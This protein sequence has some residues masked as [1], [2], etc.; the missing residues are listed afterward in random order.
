[1][2]RAVAEKLQAVADNLVVESEEVSL[3]SNLLQQLKTALDGKATCGGGSDDGSYDEGYAAGQQA[4][5]DRFWDA[6]QQ[7]GNRTDYRSAFFG[8]GWDG[9]SFRPK[10][11]IKAVGSAAAM[12]QFMYFDRNRSNTDLVDLSN[13]QFDVSETTDAYNMFS[14]ASVDSV[15][16]AF[17]EK[18]TS[19]N[20]AFTKGERGNVLGMN[21]TLCMPNPNCNVTNMFSYHNVRSLNLL[22]GSIIGQNGMSLRWALG[23]SKADITSVVNALSA[24][25]SGLTVTLSQTAVNAAF[26]TASGVNDGST[27]TEWLTLAGTKTNW[28]ITLG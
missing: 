4:E 6:F 27:S 18:V 11:V 17:S 25:T 19:L 28:T 26:E 23:L 9:V 12:C 5:Y 2:T 7:N 22:P 10:Y 16:L 1:M 14:N 24:T 15:T 21:I 13:V 3:Q 8:P 20:A